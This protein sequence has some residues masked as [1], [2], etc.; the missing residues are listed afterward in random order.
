MTKIKFITTVLLLLAFLLNSEPNLVAQ[1][2]GQSDMKGY[3]NATYNG[4]ADDE[5]MKNWLILAPIK[6]NENEQKEA[7]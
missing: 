7:L 3:G 1:K 2:K 6:I 4:L 5:F